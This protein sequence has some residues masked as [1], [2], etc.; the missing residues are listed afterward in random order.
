MAITE[1]QIEERANYLGGSDAAGILGLSR[2]KTP[3]Q[4][5]MAKVHPARD[6]S[7][8]RIGGKN[9]PA[10]WG[11]KLEDKVCEAF[12]EVTGKKVYRVNETLI[13]PD[14][15]FIRANID[16]R[17]VGEDAGFE[18][19]TAS[20]YKAKEWA[21]EEMPA[22]YIIQ[23]QHYLAVTGK[24]YWYLACLIG[25][26]KF[27]WKSIPRDEELIKQII[28]AEVAFWNDFVLKK[29]PPMV[30]GR[31]QDSHLLER[32]YPEAIIGT[33]A[34]L[35]EPMAETLK[36]RAEIIST[37]KEREERLTLI[38]N[39]VKAGM[40]DAET[41]RAGQFLISWKNQSRT[42]IDSKALKERYPDI[43]EAVQKPSTF[44]VLRIKEEKENGK[45]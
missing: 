26:Q 30:T 32:L 43:F 13:H 39:E 4:V 21:D 16:R 11:N 2:W 10:Y 31:E 25:G 28:E 42:G 14:Y 33:E 36:E 40:K 1:Q 24:A 34:I 23:C 44:R 15:P 29:Q 45:G 6:D 27:I 5:F 41:A 7:E 3:L 18:A 22:E 37:I 17:V 9:E 8:S 20:A 38:E 12:T 19:K 35:P